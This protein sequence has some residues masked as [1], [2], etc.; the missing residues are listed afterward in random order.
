MKLLL[1]NIDR[2]ITE[3]Q[4]LELFQVYGTVQYC[5]I[6]MDEKTGQSKGFGFVELPNP[7]HAKSAMKNLNGYILGDSKIRVKKADD[8]KTG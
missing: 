2:T 3:A 7:G 1:R 4:L 5:T 6:V 8:K